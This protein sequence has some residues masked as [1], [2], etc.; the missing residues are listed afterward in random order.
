MRL[1]ICCRVF[2]SISWGCAF[3]S[4]C[5]IS[6]MITVVAMPLA[7]SPALY[8]PMPSASTTRPFAAS[9]ATESSLCERTMPGSV[10][11]AMSKVCFRSM[12]VDR[13]KLDVHRAAGGGRRRGAGERGAQRAGEF[14]AG[15]EALRRILRERRFDEGGDALRDG[16]VHAA[17]VG[18]RLIGDLEHELGHRFALERQLAGEHLVEGH[19]EREEIRAALDLRAGELL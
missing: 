6:V 9:A 17:D 11:L 7:T 13:S 5:C 8:P 4:T 1:P 15:L 3:C 14:L 18:R 2:G 12:R 16:R 10:A 19:G